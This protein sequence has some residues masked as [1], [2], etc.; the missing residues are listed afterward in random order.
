MTLGLV[1]GRL[2]VLCEVLDED[3]DL[4]LCGDFLNMHKVWL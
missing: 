3:A 1:I 4:L 2:N